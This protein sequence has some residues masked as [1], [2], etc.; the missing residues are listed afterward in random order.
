MQDPE[1]LREIENL[2]EEVELPQEDETWEED[3]VEGGG[4]GGVP[5]LQAVICALAVLALVFFRLTDDKKYQEIAGWYQSEMAKELELPSLDRAAPEP[6][7]TPEPT[8]S[9][10]PPVQASAP[11]QML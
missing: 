9:P 11:L 6:S 7:G 8:A 4:W 10:A 1:K 3:R 5:L 2:G